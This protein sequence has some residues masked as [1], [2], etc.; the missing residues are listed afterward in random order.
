M[1]RPTVFASTSWALANDSNLSQRTLA[2]LRKVEND[3]ARLAVSLRGALQ[4]KNIETLKLVVQISD[5]RFRQASSEFAQDAFK[6]IST[7]ATLM[8]AELAKRTT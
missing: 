8:I 5:E 1:K 3:P 6:Q 4:S 2:V 7:D